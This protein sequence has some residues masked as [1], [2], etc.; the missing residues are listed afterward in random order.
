VDLRQNRRYRL[1]ATV[2]FEWESADGL[3]HQAAGRTR[4]ISSA[5][6]FIISQEL[7][8]IGVAVDLVVNL[9][10]LQDDGSGAQMKTQGH[11]VRTDP[12]GFAVIADI[13]F[14][15]KVSESQA[16]NRSYN[17]QGMSKVFTAFR[18]K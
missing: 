6:V 9:P 18:C 15:M 13:G 2:N 17:G 3:S 16:I 7:L 8:P 11:V 4:D 1:V 5:G 14:R 12:S 10:S